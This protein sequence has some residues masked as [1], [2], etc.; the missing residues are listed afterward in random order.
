MLGAALAQAA[1]RNLADFAQEALFTP[2]G[3]GAPRWPRDG[4][5]RPLAC[6][7]AHLTPR[8]LLRL[9]QLVLQG[10]DWEGRSL[11][12]GAWIQEAT[13]AHVEGY[14]WMEGLPGYGLLWWVTREGGAEAWYATGYGGQ[15]VAVFPALELVAVMTGRVGDHPNHRHVIAEGMRAAVL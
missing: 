3:I 10:G 6:G 13:R 12:P 9:G 7:S 11:V 15:Y 2:L 14:L 1:G 4:Q 8:E 5:G